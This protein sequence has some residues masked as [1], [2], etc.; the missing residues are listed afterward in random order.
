MDEAATI[1]EDKPLWRRIVD[2]PL[3]AMLMGIA[4][5]FLGISAAGLTA[6]FVP[7]IRGLTPH[8]IFDLICAPVLIILY[9]LVIRHLG[10]IRRD[11]LRVAGALKPLVLGLG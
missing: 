8:L 3:V 11:D 6:K 2:F 10:E 4:V 7:P 9:K 5:V 1:F